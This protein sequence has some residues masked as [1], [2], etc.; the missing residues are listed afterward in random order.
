MNGKKAKLLRKLATGQH[1]FQPTQYGAVE[2]SQRRRQVKNEM[3]AVIATLNTATIQMV[4]GTR[5]L[6]K[7]LKAMYKES[8]GLGVMA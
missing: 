8:I 3:G 7:K 5:Y 6:N 2:G 4:A 1:D